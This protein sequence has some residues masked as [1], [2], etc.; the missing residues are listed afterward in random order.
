[1]DLIADDASGRVA[2]LVERLGRLAQGLQH[3]QGLKPAQWEALRYLARA[4][5]YSRSPSALAD[6]LGA[7]RG[8][9]SQTLISLERKGLISRLASARDGRSRDLAVTPAGRRL[10]AAD[11]LAELAL[12]ARSLA[13]DERAALAGGLAHL[14]RAI[15]RR[16]GSR[17]FG[18][19]AT[20]RHFLA[21]DAAGE[22]GGPNRCGLTREPL[23]EVEAGLV[24]REHDQPAT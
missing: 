8:T 9:V 3:A 11:P 1:M 5:R 2:A 10:V 4:N 17:A 13:D 18:V 6:F 16:R 24:C 15:Q 12:A 7:T 19:C 21:G 14:L 22:P 23:S 20:C